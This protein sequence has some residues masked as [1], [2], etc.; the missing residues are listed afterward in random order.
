LYVFA[1]S[2]R[3]LLGV[4]KYVV[5]FP[6]P[7]STFPELSGRIRAVTATFTPVK[8]TGVCTELEYEYEMFRANHDTLLEYL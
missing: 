3:P 2:F 6:P 4:D 8:L 7:L 1:N 5:Y